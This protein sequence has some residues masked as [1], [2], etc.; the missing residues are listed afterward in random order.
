MAAIAFDFGMLRS[1][2]DDRFD[3]LDRRIS[4]VGA[5]GAALSHMTASAAGIRSQNRLAVG[6]GHYCG[7]NA[8]ALGYQRAMSERMVFTLGAAFNGDDNAA[9]AGVA[10]GW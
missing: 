5:M 1:E 9:G 4:Q 2:M 3:R 7:E 6:V 8:I 10:W